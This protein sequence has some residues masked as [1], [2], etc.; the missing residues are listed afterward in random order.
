[1]RVRRGVKDPDAPDMPIGGW[2]GTV[3]EVDRGSQPFGYHVEWDRR[4]LENMH[5]VFVK[6]CRRDD[7]EIESMWLDQDDLEAD[8]GDLLPIEQ[9]TALVTRP[10][11][12]EDQEDRVAKFSA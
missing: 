1:M 10:L 3:A 6:R 12:S 9:P 2:C 7:L 4:T 11:R 5:P 8:G